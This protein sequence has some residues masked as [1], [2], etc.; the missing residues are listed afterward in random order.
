MPLITT[1]KLPIK[2]SCYPS[3]SKASSSRNSVSTCFMSDELQD[4]HIPTE[5]SIVNEITKD[6]NVCSLEFIPDMKEDKNISK[7]ELFM[8]NEKT[9]RRMDDEETDLKRVQ[10][11]KPIQRKGECVFESYFPA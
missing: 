9:S 3:I 5:Q 7:D 11:E 10:E 4:I 2:K 6:M 1:A 8:V